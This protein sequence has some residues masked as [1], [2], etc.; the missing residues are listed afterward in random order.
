MDK[1]EDPVAAGV[2]AGDKVRPGYRG[3]GRD[4]GPEILKSAKLGYS[5][6]V[7]EFIVLEHLPDDPGIHPVKSQDDDFFLFS[8]SGGTGKK[9]SQAN[10]DKNAP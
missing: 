9:K 7:G 4:R 10:H 3:L 1:V 5:F 8:C 2:L 6:K